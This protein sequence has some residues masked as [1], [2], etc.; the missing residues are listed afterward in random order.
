LNTPTYFAMDSLTVTDGVLPEPTTL[1]MMGLGGM[2][3]LR[4]R[5]AQ[6]DQ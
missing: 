2:T 6:M 5:N 1:L 3:L 4:K